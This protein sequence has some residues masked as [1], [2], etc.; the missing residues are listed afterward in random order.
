MSSSL[1]NEDPAIS[2]EPNWQT[3][4]EDIEKLRAD[5]TALGEKSLAEGQER[6]A[7]ELA[8][9]RAKAAAVAAKVNYTGRSAH[10]DLINYVRT[11][12]ITSVSGAF[13]L[14]ILLSAF[15]SRRS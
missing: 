6:L 1:D 5:L 13:G 3:I 14:G 15:L 7:E 11:N 12:P 9:L 10:A 8:Q 2:E 4:R